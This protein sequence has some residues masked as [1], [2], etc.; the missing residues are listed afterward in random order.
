M[1][2]TTLVKNQSYWNLNELLRAFMP[3]PALAAVLSL[4]A[5]G[6]G[7]HAVSPSN[8]TSKPVPTS[9][10]PEN[11]VEKDQ[12]QQIPTPD[13]QSSENAPFLPDYKPFPLLWEQGRP[14]NIPWSHYLYS[15]IATDGSDLFNTDVQ[16]VADFCPKYAQL[17]VDQRVNFWAFL[18]SAI[19][20]FESNYDPTDRFPETGMGTDP[21][22]HQRVYSEG[23][24]QMSYQD[25][26]HYGSDCNFDRLADQNLGVKDPKRSI[27]DPYRNLKCGVHV[28]NKQI[29]RYK[30]I[31][32]TQGGYWSTI[33]PNH[34]NELT[35]IKAYTRKIPFCEAGG[36]A[37]TDDKSIDANQIMGLS[38]QEY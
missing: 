9:P 28:L 32:V 1:Y 22:T 21:V 5:C 33:M 30:K 15:I 7:F 24:L 34:H 35:G 18:F 36:A 38:S 37:A 13:S 3:L 12:S 27:L 31:E 25:T 23:L 10:A 4:V 6:G 11:P 19:A 14:E 29:A 2:G 16:D 20:R 8:P 26:L 17:T